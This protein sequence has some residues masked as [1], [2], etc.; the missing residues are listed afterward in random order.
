MRLFL[1]DRGSPVLAVAET[2]LDGS[3]ADEEIA[4]GGYNLVRLD[5]STAPNRGGIVVYVKKNVEFSVVTMESH[6]KPC[7]CENLWLKLTFGVK[8]SLI[9]GAIYRSHQNKDFI[10]HIAMD[11]NAVVTLKHPILLIG[12]FN[13]DLKK[14]SGVVEEYKRTMDSYLLEQL[15]HSPTRITESSSTLIDHAW[16]SDEDIVL[17]SDTLPGLTCASLNSGC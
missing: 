7:K 3:H 8:R 14:S 5:R 11:L 6:H 1:E 15:I 17:E 16:I 9:L 10:Q 12:D 4:V 13:Y 2:W